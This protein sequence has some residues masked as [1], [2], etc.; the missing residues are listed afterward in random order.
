MRRHNPEAFD[1]AGFS[2]AD[3]GGGD[4]PGEHFGNFKDFLSS[5]KHHELEDPRL[6]ALW[7]NLKLMQRLLL[8]SF[9]LLLITFLVF[10]ADP[11][12]VGAFLLDF[13]RQPNC[14]HIWTRCLGE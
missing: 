5:G 1:R 7:R 9:S 3:W 12:G 11:A 6:D 2:P 14:A 13:F 8:V 4:N 10:R